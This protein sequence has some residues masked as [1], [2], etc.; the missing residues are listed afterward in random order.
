[1]LWRDPR[2][3]LSSIIE[4]WRS[5]YWKTYNGLPGFEGPWS[6]LLPPGWR[7]MKERPL[8]AIAA[9]QWDTTYRIVLDDLGHIE[10]ERWTAV[11]YAQ[12][13]GNTAATIRDLFEFIGV[14]FDEAMERY[15]Q[16]PLPLSRYTL[17]APEPGKWRRNQALVESALPTV[18]HT[19]QRLR[20]VQFRGGDQAGT[21]RGTTVTLRSDSHTVR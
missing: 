7:E 14:P 12:L 3:N 11:S 17:S 15:V 19:W 10:N 18:M 5:G 13:V 8:E 6:L 2:E 16:S 4:A 21:W 9:F 1:V 20:A